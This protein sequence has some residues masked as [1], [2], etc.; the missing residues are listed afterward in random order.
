MSQHTSTSARQPKSLAA[1][2]NSRYVSALNTLRGKKARRKIVAYV[3]SYDDVTFWSSLLR[4]LETDTF[5]FEV[6]LP[7][8]TSLCKGKKVALSNQLGER[9]GDYMIACVDADYDY[10]MQGATPNSALLYQNPYVF[11]TYV[12]AIE[13]FHCY[14]A[15]LSDVCVTAT[16]ND[17]RVFDIEAFLTAYSQII[18]PLFVWNIGAYRYA[19]GKPFSLLDLA[20]TVAMP[21]ANV[22]RPNESL[23]K[24]R[25]RVNAKIARLQKA[26]PQARK[27]YKPLRDTLFQLGLTP[28]T[29]YLFVRGHDLQDSVVLPLLQTI[30]D[31]LR[32]ERERE[33]RKQAIHSTQMQ[34]ELAGYSHATMP[35]EEVLR[36]NKGYTTC[37][38]YERIQDDIRHFL[39]HIQTTHEDNTSAS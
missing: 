28:E 8:S 36:R 21:D 5:Y 16:L 3:E 2:A 18:W 13:S 31:Q 19:G 39:N 7:S 22:Y 32:R 34:N 9:L 33:I 6:M 30:C 29:T 12:Y 15:S 14:A 17:R 37:P 10:L 1:Y 4:P 25:H 20:R 35:V 11:H 38:W 26:F 27:T 23:E 24:L